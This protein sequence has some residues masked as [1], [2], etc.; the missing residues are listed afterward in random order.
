M[1]LTSKQRTKVNAALAIIQSEG[2]N[3]NAVSHAARS[4][5]SR[6][7]DARRSYEMALNEFAKSSPEV[8]PL[9]AQATR[10]IEASDDA[11]VG[12]Y[13][14]AVDHYNQTGDLSRV[15]ALSPM[16]AQDSIAL[17]VKDG[18]L[19]PEDAGRPEALEIAM[20]YAPSEEFAAAHTAN[21]APASQVAP[22][23]PETLPAPARSSSF[24]FSS[25]GLVN[26]AQAGVTERVTG[27]RAPMTAEKEKAWAG[28]PTGSAGV[29]TAGGGYRAPMTG[30]R[31]ARWAGNAT[32]M[33][34]SAIRA[35]EGTEA[36]A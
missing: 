30:E 13:A 15:N 28:T 23:A 34:L 6:G 4:Y 33:S 22:A 31:A 35:G 7:Y 26:G 1:T 16:I 8:G 18:H 11:T 32:G 10:L 29:R 19:S 14:S 17:A 36:A 5:M 9:L 3:A 25:G 24:A 20:G 21:P 27:V 2:H 12:M